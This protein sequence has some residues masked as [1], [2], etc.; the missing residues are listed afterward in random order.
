MIEA[1]EVTVDL[2]RVYDPRRNEKQLLFHRAPETYKLFGGA[3]G[4]GKTAALIN[5][6]IAL[7]F[8][9]PGNFGLFMRKTWP[10]FRDTVM[11]QFER[12]L[13]RELI[14]DWNRSDKMILLRNGS[15][16][17]YGG[18]GD[19]PDDWQKFMSGE[20]GWIAWDQAEEFT[21]EEFRM[22]ATRLRLRLAG[23]RYFFLLSCNPTQ[24]WIKPRFIEKREPDH[25]FI[26]SLPTDNVEN[27]PAGYIPR[28]REILE[29]KN[30]IEAYLEGNWDA[31]GEPD[32]VYGYG[33]VA[34]AMARTV[35]P[36][37][38]VEIG[39][40]V[41]RSGDDETVIALREGMRVSII[42]TAKGHDTMRTAGENWRI[43]RERILPRWGERLR[44]LRIKVDADGL[45]AGVVDR[46]QEQRKEKEEE[47]TGLILGAL[48][49]ERAEKLKA[50]GYRLNLEVVEIHGAGKPRQ[51][52]KFRNL[53]A[54]IHWAL[55]EVL[56]SVA[57]PQDPELRTQLLSIKYRINSAGQIEIEPKEE[58]K[59]RL[60]KGR[61]CGGSPDRAEAVIYALADV[62]PR[63]VHAWRLG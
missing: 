47:L 27:L 18:L 8:D 1:R 14:A 30:L 63:E 57:L 4:G 5:E 26:P 52:A 37:E 31:V 59:K 36:S 17:R 44:K 56:D 13:A 24:G 45:G 54:E 49:K 61:E 2:S 48:P 51:P 11:P 25:V 22:M 21:E 53:R 16:I 43:V 10:S 7:S 42:H 46:L 35:E 32:N 50:E 34:A 40:D 9:Y 12:F 6:G 55:R 33:K 19:D 58:I 20:Y 29:D 23:I 41:A 28:M 39:N 15:R 38:P 60:G 62:R 3:M